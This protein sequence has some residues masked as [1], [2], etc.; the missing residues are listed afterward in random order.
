M[1]WNKLRFFFLLKLQSEVTFFVLFLNRIGKPCWR[2]DCTL[3]AKNWGLS[4]YLCARCPWPCSIVSLDLVASLEETE[5]RCYSPHFREGKLRLWGCRT[6]SSSH[7]SLRASENSRLAPHFFLSWHNLS[8]CH[9][10][11]FCNQYQW[12]RIFGGNSESTT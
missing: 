7:W 8:H 2:P 10:L 3:L 11:W 6:Y 9:K 1:W 12:F 4:K 5:G